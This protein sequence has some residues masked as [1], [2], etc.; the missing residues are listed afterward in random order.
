[1][2]LAGLLL[3]VLLGNCSR[4][5]SAALSAAAAAADTAAVHLYSAVA[6]FSQFMFDI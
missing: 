4:N 3:L 6:V 2:A 1:M 5:P